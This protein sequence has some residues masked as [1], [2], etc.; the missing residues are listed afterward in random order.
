[1]PKNLNFLL[2]RNAIYSQLTSSVKRSKSGNSII[3]HLSTS[4]VSKEEVVGSYGEALNTHEKFTTQLVEKAVDKLKDEMASESDKTRQE[5]NENIKKEA[6]KISDTIQ[7]VEEAVKKLEIDTK[8]KSDIIVR[9][10][11]TNVNEEIGKI[12]KQYKEHTYKFWAVLSVASI[13][14]TVVYSTIRKDIN[15]ATDRLLLTIGEG[16]RSE[17]IGQLEILRKQLI[18]KE[19]YLKELNNKLEN[20][21]PRPWPSYRSM[22][23]EIINKLQSDIDILKNDTRKLEYDINKLPGAKKV[24]LPILNSD[25][26]ELRAKESSSSS[27]T[28]LS[29]QAKNTEVNQNENGIKKISASDSQLKQEIISDN[30]SNDKA[31]L[32]SEG[33]TAEEASISPGTRC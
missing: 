30:K 15:K 5:F 6:G 32:N 20:T 33:A 23:R 24:E 17:K 21:W 1:M 8:L 12:S 9:G 13:L 26:G 3:R 29:L 28:K 11:K 14:V 10:F 2:W 25:S 19:K 4:N 31:T 16:Q 7:Q 18:E 27:E 22:Y